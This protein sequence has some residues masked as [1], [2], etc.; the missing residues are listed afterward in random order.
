MSTPDQ[1]LL[2]AL[3]TVFGTQATKHE[4]STAHVLTVLNKLLGRTASS[5]TE[6]ELIEHLRPLEW[7]HPRPGKGRQH[8]LLWRFSNANGGRTAQVGKRKQRLRK[9]RS[10]AESMKLKQ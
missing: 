7:A 4:Y 1:L 2:D 6:A 9:E 5:I 10:V 8:P 3:E